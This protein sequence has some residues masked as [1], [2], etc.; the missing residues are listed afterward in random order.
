MKNKDYLKQAY[1]WVKQE[2][3]KHF[4]DP[5]NMDDSPPLQ[6][7]AGDV[8]KLAIS[9][10]TKYQIK[11]L[12]LILQ[13]VAERESSSQSLKSVKNFLRE[14]WDLIFKTELEYFYAPKHVLTKICLEIATQLEC[15]FTMHRYQLM[16][17]T[18]SI[19][20]L[21]TQTSMIED[22]RDEEGITLPESQR[23][24]LQEFILS[25]SGSHII[26]IPEVFDWAIED[27]ILKHTHKLTV[28]GRPQPLN[29]KEMQRLMA[30]SKDAVAVKASLDSLIAARKTSQTVGAAVYRLCES[31]NRGGVEASE[32]FTIMNR[33]SDEVAG[34]DA[35]LGVVNFFGYL[36]AL[37]P[38]IQRDLLELRSTQNYTAL[39]F[40]GCWVQLLYRTWLEGY[41]EISIEEVNHIMEYLL[42]NP[43]EEDTFICVQQIAIDFK[44]MIKASALVDYVPANTE[45][46][47]RMSLDNE[48]FSYR[49][50]IQDFKY[51]ISISSMQL[52]PAPL[53]IYD[54][55]KFKKIVF[56]QVIKGA[57]K[58]NQYLALLK[59]EKDKISL[60]KEIMGKTFFKKIASDPT[61]IGILLCVDG[62]KI[63]Q[64][65]LET[66]GMDFIW[67]K[68]STVQDIH[69]VI[70]NVFIDNYAKLFSDE[71]TTKVSNIL[72]DFKA[73][74]QFLN[75]YTEDTCPYL[76]PFMPIYPQPNPIPVPALK[77]VTV[78][79]LSFFGCRQGTS[80]KAPR[81]ELPDSETARPFKRCKNS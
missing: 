67:G 24:N 45:I 44:R 10:E 5:D 52:A 56:R 71:S 57:D 16:M 53:N 54:P 33:G 80:L 37:S 29:A 7:E 70:K 49:K 35:Y 77:H 36:K 74:E 51:A 13:H 17:P 18:I 40:E 61:Q 21:L 9:I 43:L 47:N 4:S 59:S 46:A 30:H 65:I 3:I 79:L 12:Y 8:K 50:R 68:I 42:S 27:G 23:L 58:L 6:A 75:Y 73:V 14:R 25:E 76:K 72:K 41:I 15:I 20:N 39:T 34:E 60:V 62:V 81:K 48:E 64:V 2:Y 55:T 69:R 26:N 66:L 28:E 32:Q 19:E 1:E 22:D 38:D 78:S 63:Q 11:K 31:L